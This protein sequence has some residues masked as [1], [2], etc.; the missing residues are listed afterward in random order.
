M[1]NVLSKNLTRLHVLEETLGSGKTFFI[2][3]FTH[4]LQ[5]QGKNVLLTSITKANVLWLS[6]H[7]CT[8]HV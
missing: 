3:Y 1:L 2:K 7:A 6:Q 5:M 4:Y 8:T